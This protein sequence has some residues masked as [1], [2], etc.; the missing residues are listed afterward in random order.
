MAAGTWCDQVHCIRSGELSPLYS[1]SLGSHMWN[2]KPTLKVDSSSSTNLG[3]LSQTCPEAHLS[4]KS[5]SRQPFC[6]CLYWGLLHLRH[7]CSFHIFTDCTHQT[8]PKGK[9]SWCN[10]SVLSLRSLNSYLIIALQIQLIVW[11]IHFSFLLAVR[12]CITFKFYP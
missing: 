5:R 4:I 1:L 9:S 3:H 6:L 12:V 2:G 10:H 7:K 8:R 11:R